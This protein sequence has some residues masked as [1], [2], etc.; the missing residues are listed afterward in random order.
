MI[1]K[2]FIVLYVIAHGI[3]GDGSTHFLEN[4]CIEKCYIYFRNTDSYIITLRNL[5]NFMNR[6]VYKKNYS[7]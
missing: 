7:R 3:V 1:S 6:Y 4:F 2:H 5:G